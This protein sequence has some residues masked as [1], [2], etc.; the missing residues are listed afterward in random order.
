MEVFSVYLE[1]FLP[2]IIIGI[3]TG[4][5]VFKI[6]ESYLVASLFSGVAMLILVDLSQYRVRFS[7]SGEPFLLIA[8]ALIAIVIVIIN[9]ITPYMKSN[10]IVV[11]NKKT[12]PIE[13]V[14]SIRAKNKFNSRSIKRGM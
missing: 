2:M 6:K 4:V 13:K 10:N 11:S 3:M 7:M 9:I 5:L 14:N 1:V 8:F 12:P